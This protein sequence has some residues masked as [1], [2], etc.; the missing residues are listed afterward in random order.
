MHQIKHQMDS[1]ITCT[2]A[3]FFYIQAAELSWVVFHCSVLNFDS[4]L[5]RV[6]F[7]CSVLNFDSALSWVVLCCL[8]LSMSVNAESESIVWWSARSSVVRAEH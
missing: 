5:S 7:H 2:S 6:V 1:D 4:A 3:Q 8:V